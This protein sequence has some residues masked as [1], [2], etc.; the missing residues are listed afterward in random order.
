MT[1]THDPPERPL[2]EDLRY[3]I[4]DVTHQV[5]NH[6]AVILGR[7]GL[8]TL[9]DPG[10]AQFAEAIAAIDRSVRAGHEQVNRLVALLD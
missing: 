1:P 4:A 5:I 10:N 7:V 6:L 8:M 2:P 3:V 9:D